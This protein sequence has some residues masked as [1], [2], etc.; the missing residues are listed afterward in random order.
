MRRLFP[1]GIV[2]LLALLIVAGA[3]I[4]REQATVREE[5]PGGI[6]ERIQQQRERINQGIRSGELTRREAGILLD[7]LDWIRDRFRR[8]SAD[9]RLTPEERARLETMLDQNN[10]MIYNKKHNA[11]RRLERY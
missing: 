3:C 5:R 6:E 10:E 9:R 11:V 4:V 8:M 1:I 2:A 7:N